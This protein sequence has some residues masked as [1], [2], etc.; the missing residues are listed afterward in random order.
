MK[1]NKEQIAF[2]AVVAVLGYM[3]WNLVS[4]TAADDARKS[5]K[6]MSRGGRAEAPPELETLAGALIGTDEVSWSTGG[7]NVF[8][9]P[10]EVEPM[11]PIDVPPPPR[12]T[13][14][15]APPNPVPGPDVFNRLSRIATIETV[16]GVELPPRE[17]SIFPDED[18]EEETAEASNDEATP[19]SRP[20]SRPSGTARGTGVLGLRERAKRRELQ[21]LEEE[22][23]RLR[24]S[25]EEEERRRR[26]DKV[27]WVNGDVWYGEVVND[28]ELPPGAEGLTRYDIKLRIDSV[29]NDAGLAT[30]QRRAALADRN[31]EI[32]FRRDQNGRL[33]TP[34][35]L[36]AANV[37]A[38]EF[39]ESAVNEF[40]VKRRQTAAD[41][42]D[43]HLALASNL[44]AEGEFERA[45]R[46]L[47]GLIERGHDRRDV[48][49]RLSTAARR[50]FDY[51]VELQAL[52]DGLAR[53]EG[54]ADLLGA[55]GR[56]YS[57]IGLRE[58]A[59]EQLKRALEAAPRN[60]RVQA[61]WGRHILDGGLHHRGEAE[62]AFEH[63]RRA[64]RGRFELADEKL[65]ILCDLAEAALAT[66][67][68]SQAGRNFG[69]VLAQDEDHVRA[70]VGLGAVTYLQGDH[71][72]ARGHL[73]AA[74]EKDPYHG[75]AF[76]NLGLVLMAQEAWVDA[77]DRLYDSIEADPLLTAQAHAA[78]GYLHE[79][80][81]DP[82]KALA[83]Y[84][85]ARDADGRDPEIALLT[86][87]GYLRNGDPTAAAELL[88]QAAIGMPEQYDVLAHSADAALERSSW[89]TSLR[90]IERAYEFAKEKSKVA[91]ETLL[92]R[93]AQAL[94]QTGQLD[95][96]K[97]TLEEARRQR[98]TDRVELGLAHYYYVEGNHNEALKRFQAVARDLEK[99]ESPLAEYA[100]RY[101]VA[102][103][104]NL[105]KT[106]WTDHFNRV[107]TGGDLLRDWRSHAPGSGVNITL[108]RNQVAFKGTQRQS[109]VC[110]SILQR[111]QGGEL[112]SFEASV[113][114]DR[115]MAAYAGIALLTFRN[116]RKEQNPYVDLFSGG[117]A[118][119][120]LLLAKTPD[121]K[122]AWRQV[123]KAEAGRWQIVENLAWPKKGGDSVRPVRFGIEVADRKK[124]TFVLRMDGQTVADSVVQRTLAK[125]KDAQLW[126]FTQAEIDRLVDV[127]F[128]DVRIV[129]KRKKR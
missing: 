18:P 83:E 67:N 110:S 14:P 53:Y 109:D 64:S 30:A 29:R 88:D 80:L 96:A 72:A 124:G 16:D 97:K 69:D 12:V 7:R 82:Q 111:R 90:Y 99:D 21:L 65:E 19:S 74:L 127:C 55:L 101:A 1:L 59:E 103:E 85:A 117:R 58:L 94:V 41:D 81:G 76:F 121:G 8:R 57:R 17:G 98:A 63:L 13:L 50:A 31:L 9:A 118:F 3:A 49:V 126:A 122:V 48:W 37:R 46:H 26:L 51:D 123:R 43:G 71:D 25:R 77:R 15:L 108:N 11:P 112:V 10:R 91:A 42:V 105:A 23:E 114:A 84:E 120:A 4:S 54:D 70:K 119:D 93:K 6:K 106:V 95:D 24:K 32:R 2:F 44:M 87:R 79:R 100:R 22:R 35:V 40:E 89:P 27:F 34:Q 36:Q 73:E 61:A 125:A 129:T 78:L 5:L 56:F 68:L 66:G 104:D 92:V 38:L 116:N 20:S 33:R 39:G 115:D 102:I 52:Q 86:A 45:K 107:S 75:A 28:A 60:P 62:R 47:T 113:F 128:D